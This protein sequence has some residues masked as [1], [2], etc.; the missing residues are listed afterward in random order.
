MSEIK[1]IKCDLC[2]VVS[3]PLNGWGVYLCYGG[4]SKNVSIDLCP[5]CTG[6][7]ERLMENIKSSPVNRCMDSN[8]L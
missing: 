4:Y 7:V 2:G 8:K 5:E 1:Y 6:K 3:E